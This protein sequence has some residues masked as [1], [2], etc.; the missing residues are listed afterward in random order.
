MALQ[1]SITDVP[2]IRV[3][4]AHDAEAL[5]GCTVV[6]CEGGAV[7]GVDQRGGAPGTRETEL[8]RPMHHVQE[9]QAV[10]LSGGSAFGLDSASG[11]VRYL[12][13]KG[14]GYDARGI[15]V[16][17]VP[18]VIL[19][20]LRV[21]R[22]D[23]RPDAD[24]GYTAC[25]NA[26]S[27]KPDE[28][29]AGAGMGA[30]V[31]KILGMAGAM[32]SGIG[33]ASVDLGGGVV[34]GAI[35]AVNPLGDVVD[36]NSREIIAGTRPAKV[37]PVRFGGEGVFADTLALMKSMPGKT[38]LKIASR[39][40]TVIG[41]VATNAALTKEGANKVAQ[42]AHNGIALSVR[43]AHTMQDGD[44][45]FAL[46]TG[47]KTMDVNIVG[48]YAVEVVAQSIKNAVLHAE[49]VAGIPAASNLNNEAG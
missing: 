9:V 16:P 45:L 5:T 4:H 12:E 40:N 13:E 31:G 33:T 44:T 8:L 17:I 20:D 42:M 1:N 28:G 19:F 38:I 2:G 41:V 43:P 11:V 21:G 7:G 36:P 35:V 25:L 14:I 15:R 3:G 47:K 49:G 22:S 24:M 46:S 6:L 18:A 48:A 30:T 32:K 10:V 37:G 27:D 34:V 39:A 26:S 29:N 23:V